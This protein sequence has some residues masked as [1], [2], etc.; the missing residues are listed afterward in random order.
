MTAS[1][2]LTLRELQRDELGAATRLLGRGM[3]DN[4]ANV[5]AFG[6]RDTDRPG[7]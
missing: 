5:R 7:H 4:P 3:C 2:P 1:L 6:M